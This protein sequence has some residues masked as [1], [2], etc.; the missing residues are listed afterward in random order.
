MDQNVKK[1]KFYCLDAQH[2]IQRWALTLGGYDYTIQYKEGKNMANADALSRLPLK[3]PDTQVP[4]PPEL[5]HLV[6]HLNTTPLSWKQIRIWTDHDP[7]LTRVK[8]LVQDGWPASEGL[9]NPDLQPYSSVRRGGVRGGSTE[10]PFLQRSA[11]SI[12]SLAMRGVMGWAGSCCL[13]YER[14]RYLYIFSL[15]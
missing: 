2:C 14:C 15:V 10:P 5:V 12:V 11:R 1:D 6:E 4:K 7:T 13:S 8:K 9:N 3:T